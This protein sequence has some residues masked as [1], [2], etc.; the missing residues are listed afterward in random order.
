MTSIIYNN[1]IC[2]YG[3]ETRQH[4]AHC[5]LLEDI[6]Y[7]EFSTVSYVTSI[8]YSQASMRRHSNTAH[9]QAHKT[10]DPFSLCMHDLLDEFNIHVI[11]LS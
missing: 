5:L 7:P 11:N 8:L 3:R 1:I 10:L 9:T 6:I 2:V 4:R